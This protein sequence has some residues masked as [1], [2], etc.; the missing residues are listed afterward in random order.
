[1]PLPSPQ[2]AHC[3]CDKYVRCF[4]GYCIADL[5]MYIIRG[6]MFRKFPSC[7]VG[8]CCKWESRARV[9]SCLKFQVS[10]KRIC[11]FLC[12]CLLSC[13]T[14]PGILV[15]HSQLDSLG[16]AVIFEYSVEP[17]FNILVFDIFAR[18]D[19]PIQNRDIPNL[20]RT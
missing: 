20:I 5:L 10:S 11:I 2:L 8:L 6:R 13:S 19:V 9:T 14:L 4:N 17:S 12:R 15:P 1:M 7:F 3:V 18:N 16:I